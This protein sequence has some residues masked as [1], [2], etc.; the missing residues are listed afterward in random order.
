MNGFLYFL[1][2]FS[3]SCVDRGGEILPGLL[4]TITTRVLTTDKCNGVSCCK[5]RD[6]C[7]AQLKPPC[8]TAQKHESLPFGY[9]GRRRGERTIS[10][11]R[12]V[13]DFTLLLFLVSLYHLLPDHRS[14]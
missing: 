13:F 4:C 3:Y 7:N 9:D 5:D 12:I 1:T 6:F 11:M 14:V 2:C 8:N 10:V